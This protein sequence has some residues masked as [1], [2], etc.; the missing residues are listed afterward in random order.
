[1]DLG[2]AASSFPASNVWSD[3]ALTLPH[4]LASKRYVDL[5]T[6]C[7]IGPYLHEGAQRLS[8]DEVFA[9]MPIAM[10]VPSD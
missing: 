6:G 10:L 8:M 3:M 1:M 9:R 2:I 7:A 5:L 4:D